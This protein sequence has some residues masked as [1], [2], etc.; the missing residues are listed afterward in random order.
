M[1]QEIAQHLLDISKLT[2][3]YKHFLFSV[4][5]PLP[6]MRLT[7]T[8]SKGRDAALLWAWLHEHTYIC[9][10][11]Y[12]YIY[13]YTH[14]LSH[15]HT[16][17]HTHILLQQKST[18]NKQPN[19]DRLYRTVVTFNQNENMPKYITFFE[20]GNTPCQTVWSPLA[21]MQNHHAQES[22]PTKLPGACSRGGLGWSLAWLIDALIV[23]MATEN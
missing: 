14:T 12:I 21:A 10:C 9:I 17:T 16:H 5:S 19:N 8:G 4:C 6:E 22:P 11:I 13:I 1:G 7:V 23:T 20:N 15:T 2:S 18:V 3:F